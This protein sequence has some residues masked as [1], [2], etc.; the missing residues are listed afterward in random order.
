MKT[1]YI[2]VQITE[3]GKF[4]A[5]VVRVSESD[6]LTAKLNIKGI[7][8]ANI[9]PTRKAA[10]EWVTAWNN[11]ARVNGDYMFSEPF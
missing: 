11:T 9:A 4:Y 6:N 8:A 10:R 1:Y 3:N 2:A 7:I 5:Y